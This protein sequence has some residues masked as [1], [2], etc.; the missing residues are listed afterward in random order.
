MPLNDKDLDFVLTQASVKLV[1]ASMQ[2]IKAELYAVLDEF[3]DVTSAWQEWQ[4]LDASAYTTTYQVA[5]AQGGKVIRLAGVL[6]SSNFATNALLNAAL[7]LN[8]GTQPGWTPIA[9]TM[10]DIGTLIISSPPTQAQAMSVG[11][12]KNVDT[13]ETNKKMIPLAPDWALA[14]YGRYILAGILGHMMG[15]ANKSYTNDA[16]S[17]FNLKLFQEGISRARVAAL[18]RNTY[19][20]QAWAYPRNFH[21]RGQRGYMSVGA[22]NDRSF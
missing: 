14:V 17:V 10:G 11:L 13:A 9:A 1:G 19:G 18:R 16:L 12:I 3:F 21:T 5:P 2:A 7:A 8:N 15:T 20:Q 22:G 4:P 6:A